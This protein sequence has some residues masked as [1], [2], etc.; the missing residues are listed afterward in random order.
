MKDFLKKLFFVDAPAQ[1]AFAGFTLLLAAF[2][3]V[4]SLILLSGDFSL[5]TM[6]FLT[7]VV[8]SISLLGLLFAI[9]YALIVWFR[10][11][12]CCP[13]TNEIRWNAPGNWAL[14]AAGLF[15][16]LLS[17]YFFLQSFLTG[18]KML[19]IV[20]MA[21]FASLVVILWMPLIKSPR[22]WKIILVR[23]VFLA[24]AIGSS[25]LAA[26]VLA[27]W[28][29]DTFFGGPPRRMSVPGSQK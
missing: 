15:S 25:V 6:T 8:N 3:I 16:L 9:L 2:W 18:H 12:F 7:A 23:G 28:F 26:A 11:Y 27:Y 21:V 20:G 24:A 1:G 5:N 19:I 17:G 29:M 13:Q 10:F 14:H 4:P 22:N